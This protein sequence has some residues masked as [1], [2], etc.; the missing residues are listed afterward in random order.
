MGSPDYGPTVTGGI[1]AGQSIVAAVQRKK[2]YCKAG[3]YQ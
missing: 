3:A 1:T 2:I